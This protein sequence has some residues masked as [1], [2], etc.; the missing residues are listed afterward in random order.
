MPLDSKNTYLNEHVKVQSG[1]TQQ[2]SLTERF[3]KIALCVSSLEGLL[4]FVIKPATDKVVINKNNFRT[5]LKPN[6]KLYNA[7]SS[8]FGNIG[9]TQIDVFIVENAVDNSVAP[10]P[11][12]F[13][14]LINDKQD[15]YYFWSVVTMQD[16][17]FISNIVD[18]IDHDYIQ[19]FHQS[20]NINVAGSLKSKQVL[21][22]YSECTPAPLYDYSITAQICKA[23]NIAKANQFLL[24][25]I[26][27]SELL[28][29][30][31]SGYDAT[32]VMVGNLD[33]TLTNSLKE[34]NT[35]Y[36]QTESY[37]ND[38]I[39]LFSGILTD[40]T[41]AEVKYCRNY[42]DAQI[43]E[44][45]LDYIKDDFNI[46]KF[47]DESLNVELYSKIKLL[48][49]ERELAGSIKDTV[50]NFPTANEIPNG[51]KQQQKLV[52][53]DFASCSHVYGI[54]SI[55]MNYSITI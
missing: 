11:N 55:E 16:D 21:A 3:T 4:Y 40:G 14:M 22:I 27:G 53:S 34:N 9:S 8:Y 10:L 23:I 47:T 31:P 49:K 15:L 46:A 37:N 6:S 35:N 44:L 28:E 20:D 17:T 2:T 25:K 54:K 19:F 18:E 50:F 51:D 32:K 5:L 12:D 33:S 13:A 41:P 39:M 52:I 26:G 42:L 48:F 7:C 24:F 43:K 38:N 36:L 1:T 29:C 45:A 30:N